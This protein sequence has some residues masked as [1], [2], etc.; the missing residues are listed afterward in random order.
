MIHLRDFT[1]W[2]KTYQAV[3]FDVWLWKVLK[4]RVQIFLFCLYFV[5]DFTEKKNLWIY[6]QNASVYHFFNLS[7]VYSKLQLV[8]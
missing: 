4:S 2:V 6:T 7:A 8:C 5:W 1:T 3:G